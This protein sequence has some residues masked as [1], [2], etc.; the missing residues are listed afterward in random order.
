PLPISTD[1]SRA[2]FVAPTLLLHADNRMRVSQEGRFGPGL[3][4]M[5]FATEEEAIERASDI[6][7][8]LAGFV[9]TND[10]KRGHRVA[11][12]IDA[13]MRWVNAQH[14]R[15]LRTTFGGMKSSTS[16]REGSHYRFDVYTEK[17]I[18]RVSVKDHRSPPF[19][20]SGK[21]LISS[22]HEVMTNLLI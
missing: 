15:D 7:Y 2:N 9:W 10:I 3:T 17:R 8:G 6:D 13:G 1:F 16:G 19:G 11:H 12:Q 4:V 21:I 22:Q 18:I 20:N 5:T 14:V